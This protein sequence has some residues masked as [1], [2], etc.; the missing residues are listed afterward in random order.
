MSKNTHGFELDENGD[1]FYPEC[2]TCPIH[3][4]IADCDPH[5]IC[6]FDFCDLITIDL[7]PED[8]MTVVDKR[9]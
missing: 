4:S 1:P 5:D 3:P 2:R 7:Y 6:E 9:S 8:F